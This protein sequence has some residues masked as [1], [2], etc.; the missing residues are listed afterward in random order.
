MKYLIQFQINVFALVI[1]L[2]LYIFMRQSRIKTFGKRLINLSLMTT[3]IAI[4]DEPLTWIF[5][6]MHFE[7][8]YFLEYSTNFLLFLIGPVIG[9]L[10]MSYVDF[11]LFHD[12]KRI[13]NRL[14]YQHAS[15]LTLVILV[16]NIFVPIY[17]SIA[18]GTNSYSSG[19][20]KIFHYGVLG[21][22][23]GYFFLFVTMNNK[24]ISRGETLIYLIFFFIPIAGM[25]MQLVDSRLHFSWT[26]IAMGLL[27]IYVFL[28]STP[29]D[30]DYL[31]KL[32]NRN[33]FDSYLQHLIQGNISFGLMVFDLNHFKEIN[34]RY[35]HKAGDETLVYF[36]KALKQVF[37]HEG[38]A[39]RLGGDE[40]AVISEI[41]GIDDRVKIV[42]Q[43]LQ[44]QVNPLINE[45]R[46][47]FGYTRCEQGMTADELSSIAD[48]KM[49][50]QKKE[51]KFRESDFSSNNGTK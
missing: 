9:G 16:A 12:R 21:L 42:R 6:G 14:L 22:L 3:A 48:A 45:L 34:D 29:S 24:R 39:F 18:V 46:F 27:V 19:P 5:D 49:Y 17:F 33:S 37:S 44:Q 15:I 32:Y 25:L 23:Y 10:L 20:F 51:M 7:G 36:A 1:L 31:T 30:E 41:D 8:A 38:L 50:A 2:I 11:R 13:Y 35:G 43:L 26:S 47:S 28:E 4:I 40:F